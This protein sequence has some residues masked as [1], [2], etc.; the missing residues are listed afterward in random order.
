[1]K[2]LYQ[3]VTFYCAQCGRRAWEARV[4]GG[5]DPKKYAPVECGH[6]GSRRFRSEEA[7]A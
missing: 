4:P 5:Q 3:V 6:C 1:V 2:L 7:A